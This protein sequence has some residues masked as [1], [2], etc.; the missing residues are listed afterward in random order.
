M[1][2]SVAMPVSVQ[3]ALPAEVDGQ[4]MPTLAPMLER[5]TRRWSMCPARPRAG[6]QSLLRR[7]LL[8][9]FFNQPNVPQE[10]VQQSL[11]SGVIVDAARG[12]C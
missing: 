7:P 10:R 8:P 6:S 11:G 9:R 1:S 2:L 4:P 12:W 3:A 5:T